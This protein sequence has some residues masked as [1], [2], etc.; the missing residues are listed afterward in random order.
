[1]YKEFVVKNSLNYGHILE[2]FPSCTPNITDILS[3]CDGMVPRYY[4]VCSSPLAKSDRLSVA[5]SVVDYEVDLHPSLEGKLSRRRGGLATQY[6]EVHCA[7]LLAG[8]GR[9]NHNNTISIFPKPTADFRLPLAQTTP[10]I[11]IGPGTGVAPFLGFLSH[12]QQLL[13]QKRDLETQAEQGTWRGD[14]EIEEEGEKKDD[15]VDFFGAKTVLFFGCRWPDHDFLFQKELEAFTKNKTLSSLY[16]AFSR[17]NG[18][19]YVQDVM[20][21]VGNELANMICKENA[22]V[23]ICGDGNV[24]GKQVQE[25]IADILDKHG[26]SKT[27]GKLQVEEMKKKNKLVLDIWS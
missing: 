18:K 10:L 23:Y 26:D 25:C 3:M 4:S 21:T 14:Y 27:T 11:L 6:L 9:S 1:L 15:V 7:S 2:L 13:R 19:N 8:S 5:F 16:T 12:R 17:S 20:K 24:M 22:S